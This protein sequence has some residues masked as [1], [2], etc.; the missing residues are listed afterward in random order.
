MRNTP[1]TPRRVRSAHESKSATVR[2]AAA[3]PSQRQRSHWQREQ[4]QKRMLFIAIGALVVVV[5]A[6]FAGGVV[7]DNVIR[8]NQTVA[9]VGSDTI[10]ASQLLDDVRTQSR[11]LDAQAKQLGNGSNVTSYVDQQKR[12][13]PDTV[14][15]NMIDDKLIEQ[16]AAR[17]GISVAPSDLDDKERQTVADFQASNNP[18]P[19]PEPTASAEAVATPESSS[20]A[21]TAATPEATTLPVATVLTPTTPTAVPTLEDSAYG[22]ALQQLLDKNSLS[23]AELRK[24][25]Q[26]SLL[27][28]KL[29]TAIGQEKVPDTQDEVHARQIVVAAQDQAVDLVTQL[30][31]G[32]DFG[33]LATANST[34]AATKANGGDMGWFARGAQSK[35]IE[36][37]VFAMQPGQLSDVIQDP[38]GFHI[39]QLIE[40]DPARPTPP[41]QLTTQRQK[42]F[43]DWLTAQRS[44]PDVKL[45]LDQSTKDWELAHIGVRP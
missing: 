30:Q 44:G 29:Q 42:A 39:L 2:A 15:N 34:D 35:P 25:L 16:E 8:A 5:A 43:S 3:A 26:Q 36:D 27:R 7:W 13:M 21:I 45:S 11:A 23:E 1:P 18:S 10:T 6:I 41:G 14:L 24:Q 19:T 4:Q 37:A 12:S 38:A 32:G 22:T 17:R 33:Q 40:H 9:Q 28:D 31:S 20:A